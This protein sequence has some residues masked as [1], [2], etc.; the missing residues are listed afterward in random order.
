MM[1]PEI[2]PRKQPE[3]TEGAIVVE[4]T[5]S[6]ERDLKNLDPQKQKKIN[7]KI[8]SIIKLLQN[9]DLSSLHHYLNKVRI[10]SLPKYTSSMYSLRASSDLRVLLFIEDDP[11]FNQKVLT[12]LCV[13]Q[14]KD[15]NKAIKSLAESYYQQKLFAVEDTDDGE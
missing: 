1:L 8:E 5:D 7:N 12:L 9:D 3:S 14:H 10:I 2:E 13:S 11:I 6:F 15:M 4:V